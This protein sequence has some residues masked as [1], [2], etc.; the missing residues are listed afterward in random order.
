MT[1]DRFYP[2]SLDVKESERKPGIYGWA[3]RRNGKLLERSDRAHRS[4]ADARK[5]GEKAI[6]RLFGDVKSER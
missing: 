4:E 2:Y 6:E 1:T 5:D 3:I